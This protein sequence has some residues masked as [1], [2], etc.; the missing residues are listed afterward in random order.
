VFSFPCFFLCVFNV[1]LDILSAKTKRLRAIRISPGKTLISLVMSAV[2]LSIR[3]EQCDPQRTECREITY[4][5][6]VLHF[7]GLFRFWLKQ[8][9]RHFLRNVT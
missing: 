8:D 4:V 7:V 6:F 5:G 3:K 1:Y 2:R 9:K